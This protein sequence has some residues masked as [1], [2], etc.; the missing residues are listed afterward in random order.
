MIMYVIFAIIVTKNW[1]LLCNHNSSLSTR[2][3]MEKKITKSEA[4]IF[5]ID[6]C[7]FIS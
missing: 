4:S 3:S 7:I 2:L 6:G 1:V 5:F